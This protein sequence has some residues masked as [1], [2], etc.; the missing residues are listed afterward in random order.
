MNT[1]SNISPTGSAEMSDQGP[2]HGH[3]VLVSAEALDLVRGI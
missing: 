3:G 1:R 2:D